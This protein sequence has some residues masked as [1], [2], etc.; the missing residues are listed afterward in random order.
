MRTIAVINQKGGSGKTTTVVNLA[1]ALAKKKRRVLAV[2]LDGQCSATRWLGGEPSQTHKGM[3]SVL[4]GDV[5]LSEVIQQTNIEDVWVA[6]GHH[7]LFGIERVLG[8]EDVPQVILRNRL[9]PLGDGPDYVLLDCPA[10]RGLMSI[11]A[12]AAAN[13]VLIPIEIS[14]MALDGFVQLLDTVEA[15][16]KS[17]NA[18]LTICGVLAT[19]VDKRTRLSNEVL[20]QL[21]EHFPGMVLKTHIRESIRFKEAPRFQQSI[22]DYTRHGHGVKDFQ[23]LAKEIIQQE[24]QAH[25]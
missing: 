17:L 11:N 5:P 4:V 18:Q 20:A 7:D 3:F 21:H 10:Q 8:G 24:A 13:E 9:E 19:R 22:F 23:A 12:L 16:K 25:G 15:V 2:D 14:A 1:A 6:G